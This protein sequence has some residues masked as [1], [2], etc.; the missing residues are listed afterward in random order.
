MYFQAKNTLKKSTTTIS[1]SIQN[2]HV[3]VNHAKVNK[4]NT[5]RKILAFRFLSWKVFFSFLV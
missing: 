2:K 4:K 3:T 5:K 1:N